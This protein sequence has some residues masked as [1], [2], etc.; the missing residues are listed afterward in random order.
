MY[1][2]LACCWCEAERDLSRW[3]LLAAGVSP[4]ETKINLMDCIC[5]CSEVEM[6][7]YTLLVMGSWHNEIF[8]KERVARRERGNRANQVNRAHMKRQA[9]IIIKSH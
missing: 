8:T 2:V 1:V 9:S 6:R 4:K 7:S 3:F 5:L